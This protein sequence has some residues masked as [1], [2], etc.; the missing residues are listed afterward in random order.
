MKNIKFRVLRRIKKTGRITVA[1]YI[2]WRKVKTADYSEFSLIIDNEYKKLPPNEFVYNHEG[3]QLF[4]WNYKS[5]DD[6]PKKSVSL[7]SAC[8]TF[9]I[10]YEELEG[11]EWKVKD[12]WYYSTGA[13]DVDGVPIFSHYTAKDCATFPDIT[14][15][16]PLTVGAVVKWFGWFLYGLENMKLKKQLNLA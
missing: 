2:Q 7:R 12:S 9:G 10:D 11:E 4:W 8:E 3:K 13:V 6:L 1:S 15:F 16:E 5:P 14:Q